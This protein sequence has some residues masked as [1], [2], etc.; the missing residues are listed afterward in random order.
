MSLARL[1]TR[2]H[3]TSEITSEITQQIH[4]T[5]DTRISE[6]TWGAIPSDTQRV[7]WDRKLPCVSA[8]L[9]SLSILFQLSKTR[10][11]AAPDNRAIFLSFCSY[12][13]AVEVIHTNG[14]R[15]PSL[16]Q[17]CRELSFTSYL[18]IPRLN[19][20]SFSS[21]SKFTLRCP[22]LYSNSVTVAF[23]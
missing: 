9:V 11:L 15:T 17:I 23:T 19:S 14:F 5:S 22:S 7:L 13:Y 1:P 4:S 20:L 10:F 3:L 21:Y 18:K 6:I 12:S 2:F 16:L 8:T